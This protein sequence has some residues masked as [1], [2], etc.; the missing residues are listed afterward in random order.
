MLGEDLDVAV[1]DIGSRLDGIGHAE[2]QARPVQRGDLVHQH[3]AHEGV[4]E[5][6]PTGSVADLVEEAVRERRLE[7]VEGVRAPAG[8]TQ[9][10]AAV[11]VATDHRGD[12]E[13]VPCRRCQPVE[14]LPH[15][16]GKAGGQVRPA[17]C[18]TLATPLLD[19]AHQLDG[20]ER[21]AF[22]PGVDRRCQLVGH[23]VR[24]L[25]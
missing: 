24:P 14:P 3:L 19:V 7:V 18:S 16:L 22:G 1:A 4:R 8:G 25:G 23:C 10:Q 21:V 2:V 15:D 6:E 5:A 13:Q 17:R 12:V 11:D 9:Q 20:V